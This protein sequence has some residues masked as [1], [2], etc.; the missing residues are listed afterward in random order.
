MRCRKKIIIIIK[1]RVGLSF[2]VTSF[3]TGAD[4]A[5]S[6]CIRTEDE[7]VGACH[8]VGEG[9]KKLTWQMMQPTYA[10]LSAGLVGLT[11]VSCMKIRV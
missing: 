9:E 11:S 5:G 6:P 1:K 7:L 3:N 10:P 2:V 8:N 4:G